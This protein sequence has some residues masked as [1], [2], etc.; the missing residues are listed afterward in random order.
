MAW[1]PGPKR[2]AA[3][4]SVV[5]CCGSRGP[6]STDRSTSPG[7]IAHGA[8]RPETVPAIVIE[9]LRSAGMGLIERRDNALT[10]LQRFVARKPAGNRPIEIRLRESAYWKTAADAEVLQLP[11]I[12]APT[13]RPLRTRFIEIDGHEDPRNTD[14]MI[15]E[16]IV[17]L[18]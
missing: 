12:Q 1:F 16:G 11:H 15:F 3:A 7:T 13:S 4:K 8:P 17:P 10:L 5:K 2:H 6:R 9:D 18:V 14:L